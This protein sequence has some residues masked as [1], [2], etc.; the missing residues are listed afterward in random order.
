MSFEGVDFID[1]QGSAKMA[2]ILGLIDTYGA[3]LR[4]ARVKPQVIGLLTRDGVIDKLGRDHV[5]GNV[6]EA[7]RDRIDPPPT[8]S[9]E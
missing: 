4:L 5:Y 8:A 6:F 7:V 3:E 2:E 9:L 1:S